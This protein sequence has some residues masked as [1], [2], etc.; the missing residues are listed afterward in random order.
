MKICEKLTV[1]VFHTSDAGK[2]PNHTRSRSRAGIVRRA[3]IIRQHGPPD[4]HL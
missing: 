2:R 1:V 3:M 4:Q